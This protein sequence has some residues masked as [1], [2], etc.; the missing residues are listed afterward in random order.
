MLDC[1]V[2]SPAVVFSYRLA[3]VSCRR[4]S[5]VTQ[6]PMLNLNLPGWKPN[7]TT[8]TKRYV[9]ALDVLGFKQR[10]RAI[11]LPKLFMEYDHLRR[12]TLSA[13]G[14][15]TFGTLFG[16][17]HQ[18]KV[19]V[20]HVVL[21]DTVI[22]WCDA[23]GPVDDFIMGCCG[24]VAEALRTR[25]A[26]RGGIAF[27]DT[28]I[29]PNTLTFLGQPFVDAYLT[30][31][32]QEWVGVAIHPSATAGLHGRE[33]VKECRVPVKRWAWRC[34]AAL[35]HR[36]RGL[37]PESLLRSSF[38]HALAWHHHLQASETLEYL[39]KLRRAAH[40]RDHAKFA[41]ASEFVRAF[42]REG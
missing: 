41:N 30:E 2:S 24:I 18:L 12:T 7:G 3:A 26:L 32:A 17:P 21:S 37:I 16:Q 36:A 1:Y 4:P 33:D 25:V 27:G 10:L 6:E 38:T 13:A 35:P 31:G 5:A 8:V 11:G 23:N 15:T 9:A 20:P 19:N 14:V 29:E 40:P 28:I 34:R 22:A 42:P 39:E